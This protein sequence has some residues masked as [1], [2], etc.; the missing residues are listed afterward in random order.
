MKQNI[1]CPQ[2]LFNHNNLKTY[3]Y[4]S[5]HCKLRIIFR[6][7]GYIYLTADLIRSASADRKEPNFLGKQIEN[8]AIGN[9]VIIAGEGQ[10]L[11]IIYFTSYS[12]RDI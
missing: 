5:I 6:P 10:I 8:N 1:N 3:V 4:K 9:E 12:L 11:L 2:K 7:A